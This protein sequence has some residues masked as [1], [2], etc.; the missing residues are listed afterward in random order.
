MWL[1]KFPDLLNAFSHTWHL[2]FLSLVWTLMCVIS[3]SDWLNALSH[4]WHLYG[5]SPLWI[6]LCL[7]R[8]PASVN[9]LL[10]IVHSNGF[11]P[12]WLRLCIARRLS[13]S[14]HLSHSVHLY[15]LVWIFLWLY[16]APVDEKR[17]SHWVHEYTF[18]PVCLFLCLVMLPFVVNRLS[19]TVHTYGLDLSSCGCSVISV[20]SASLFL[21]INLPVHSQQHKYY[22]KCSDRKCTVFH[23]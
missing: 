9:R 7:A 1:F 21:S 8:L 5:F 22:F 10:Q 15:L 20:L 23:M 17:F 18:S 16:R 2:Y 14:Q 4:T 13:L 11:S 12:E 19:H 3:V 6:L